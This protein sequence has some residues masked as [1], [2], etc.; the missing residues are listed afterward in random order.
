VL[1]LVTGGTGFVGSH[2]VAALVRAGHRV[3]LLV[4]SR[5]R[6]EPAL[7]PFHIDRSAIEVLAG[8]VTDPDTVRVAVSGC[9]AVLHAAAV[10][11][12]DSRQTRAMRRINAR[13][14]ELVLGEAVRAGADP[15][16]HVSTAVALQQ[17]GDGLTGD[18]PVR[19]SRDPYAASKADS[20]RIARRLQAEG[21]PVV[22]TYPSSLLGPDDPHFGDG[23]RRLRDL[24][25]GRLPMWP[26]GVLPMCD[27]RSVAELH[28]AALA[29]GAGGGQPR[30]LF[31][32]GAEVTTR[33]YVQ[34]AEKVT[35]RRIPTVHV[36]ARLILPF[37]ALASA[38][39]HV[40]P[41]HLPAQLGG[42]RTIVAD[43]RVNRDQVETLGVRRRPLETTMADSIAWLYR[44]GHITARQAGTA[45][46]Q[47]DPDV[48]VAR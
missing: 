31:D 11:S 36:P 2:S 30:R 6:V 8:D 42:V 3:R 46:H 19:R 38:T 22:I 18:S 10:F 1:I 45:A 39:Q 23:L 7:A 9:D 29:P 26:G 35:G 34:T 28:L 41:F 12:F 16:V 17:T 24:L 44:N 40:V 13:A 4:R 32:A 47:P 14:T 25:T 37:A 43:L 5:D 20:E 48:A 21:A 15:V 33:E 27:V